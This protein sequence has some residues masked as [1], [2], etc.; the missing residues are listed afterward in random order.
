MNVNI[1]IPQKYNDL[2]DWQVRK[3]T[4]AIYSRMKGKILLLYIVTILV[5]KSFSLKNM[6]H[7]YILLRNI[8]LSDLSQYTD[9]VFDVTKFNR[10]PEKLKSG[11]NTFYGPADRL[12]NLTVKEYSFAD[13]FYYQYTVEKDKTALD[14]LVTT[15]YRPL[16]DVNHPQDVRMPFFKEKLSHHAPHIELMREDKKLSILLA[17]GG[18][19]EW[20]ENQ[21]PHVFPKSK[22]PKTGTSKYVPFTKIIESMARSENQPFGNYYET[23]DAN[24]YDFLGILNEEIKASKELEKKMKK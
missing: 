14:R 3:L 16:G 2:S 10:F 24:I 9:F 11:F 22:K 12:T 1:S 15:L 18:S 17:F 4:H 13:L 8:P 20:I 21:Y 7:L 5:M 23:A 19:R 6:R